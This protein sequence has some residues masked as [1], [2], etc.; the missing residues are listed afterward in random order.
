MVR[1]NSMALDKY[2]KGNDKQTNDNESQSELKCIVPHDL[3]MAFNVKVNKDQK[4]VSKSRRFSLK[5]EVS[6]LPELIQ[7]LWT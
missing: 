1:T 6:A 3:R 2:D 5:M 7:S 4:V